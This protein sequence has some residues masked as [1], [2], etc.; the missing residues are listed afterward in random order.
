MQAPAA[1]GVSQADAS[2]R[3]RRACTALEEGF[4][5]DEEGVGGGWG[6][7]DHQEGDEEA[8]EGEKGGATRHAAMEEARTVTVRLSVYACVCVLCGCWYG[9][10]KPFG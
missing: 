7:A 1:A 3:A 8:E 5:Y 4:A 6:G 9:V 2:G 10:C